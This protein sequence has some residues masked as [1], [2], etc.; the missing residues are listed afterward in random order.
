MLNTL[1]T[2]LLIQKQRQR[3]LL[4]RLLQL[5][6]LLLATSKQQRIL[7]KET[8]TDARLVLKRSNFKRLARSQ[9]KRQLLQI[10]SLDI[11]DRTGLFEDD[12]ETLYERCEAK[13]SQPRFGSTRS[14]K[15]VLSPRVRLLMTLQFL[16]E[17]LKFKI[18]AD[19]Y[20]VSPATAK[21]E[22]LSTIPILYC[23]IPQ[24][25]AWPTNFS[26]D[27]F[28]DIA[29]A[30]DATPHLRNRVHPG[31]LEYYRGD[32]KDYFLNAQIVVSLTGELWHVVFRNGHH[33]DQSVFNDSQIV[34]IFRRIY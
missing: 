21:R 5:H 33:N 31:S 1:L 22:V 15:R 27:P 3:S 17:N 11:F 18:L 28:Y 14:I 23:N 25:I 8:I 32:I 29:G 26:K 30:I 19:L 4:V 6:L 9:S 10:Q 16:R 24:S 34:S 2:Q 12:F 7:R 13:L 20:N